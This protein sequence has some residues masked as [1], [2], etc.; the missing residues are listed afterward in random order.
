MFGITQSRPGGA[1]TM[2][3]EEVSDP[4]PGPNEVVIDV[5]ASAV[6]RADILQREGNYPPPPG[7]SSILG[8]E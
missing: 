3:W 1:D 4:D 2:T 6:N 7:A 5:K 8:L